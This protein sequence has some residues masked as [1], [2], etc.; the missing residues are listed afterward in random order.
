VLIEG[1]AIA[2][3]SGMGVWRLRACVYGMLAVVA[4]LVIVQTRARGDE[5]PAPRWLDG[6]TAAGGVVRVSLEGERVLVVK[7]DTP[8]RA[9][10]GWIQLQ[11]MP[12]RG[13]AGE[14]WGQTGR[15][16]GATRTV[17]ARHWFYEFDLHARVAPGGGH[18][19]GTVE[20]S[21]TDSGQNCHSAPLSFS[22][23]P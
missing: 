12:W 17:V 8:I 18:V 22:T 4:A 6:R 9:C 13:R 5:A 7:V 20:Y 16:L 11:W 3:G 15:D 19:D 14:G 23:H 2:D 1:E 21:G 10:G